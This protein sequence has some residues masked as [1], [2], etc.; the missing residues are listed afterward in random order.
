MKADG[1][2]VGIGMVGF[3]TVGRAVAGKLE[4]RT[5]DMAQRCAGACRCG[6]CMNGAL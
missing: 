5:D 2:R 3:S 4:S 1:K 6:R